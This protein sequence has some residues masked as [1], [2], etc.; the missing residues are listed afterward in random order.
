MS[1]DLPNTIN[2][3]AGFAPAD[4]LIRNAKVLNLVNG[5]VELADISINRRTGMIVSAY[6]KD[7]E[8]VEVLDLEGELFAVPG[9]IDC[10]VHV[11]SSMVTPQ[12]FDEAVLPRGTT[13]AFCDPHEISNVLGASALQYF[14]DSSQHMLMDLM[15]GL[16]SCVPATGLETSGAT[17]NADD[18]APFINHPNV[19]GV[20]EF[21]SIGEV[22][23][24]D[25]VALEKLERFADYHID[26]HMPFGVTTGMM[27]AMKA[28]G[29]RN[30]HE[31]TDIEHARDKLKRGIQVFIREGTVCKDAKTLA[32]LVN[33]YQ[34][35]FLGFCTD[36]R[37]PVEIAEEGHIDHVVRTLIAEGA[38]IPSVYRIAS[39]SAANHFGMAGRNP[40]GW[41]PRGLIAADNLADIVLLRDLESCDIHSVYKNG[42]L[43]TADKFSSR[44]PVTPV[45]FGSIKIDEIEVEDL[46][47]F[48][49]AQN[50]PAIGLI[51][52]QVVTTYEELSV[53]VDAN[54]ER[55]ADPENDVLYIAV[56]ER[57]GRSNG[58]I[59]RGFVKGFGIREGAMAVSV[60]H[61]SHNITVVGAT[62]DDM[63]VAV[64][65]VIALDGG[66]VVVKSGEILGELALPIAG[67]MSDRTEVADTAQDQ[68]ALL[69]AVAQLESH[70]EDPLMM[71][72]FLPLCVIPDAKI[73]DFG[74]TR[75]NPEIGILEPTLVDD[76]RA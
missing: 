56:I 30:C 76:Q 37:N 10:H 38:D 24:H 16:S 68:T 58:N 36:D 2:Q 73:T 25:P 29:I 32:A 60:G 21:M 27:N 19:Y 64:N 20:A 70:W 49:E 41:K 50:V 57:H 65:R 17:L 74:I 7:R 66:K 6:E 51:K 18:L 34:S 43:V 35:P 54:G 14:V 53:I 12:V 28:C 13:T 22:L 45:G 8:G 15:V 5:S 47:S 3:A 11:E 52:D 39:W 26:G 33:E 69:K 4:F 61:D 44:E 1:H 23:N 48:G 55:F 72:G 63:V 62:H 46:R 9:F 42:E 40:K 75:F 67:L 71:L 31:N 59:A